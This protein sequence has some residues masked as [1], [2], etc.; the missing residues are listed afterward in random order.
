[1]TWFIPAARD[2]RGCIND[3]NRVDVLLLQNAVALFAQEEVAAIATQLCSK[4]HHVYLIHIYLCICDV[5]KSI[6]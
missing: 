4:T 3:V 2:C 5:K 1:M 6:T